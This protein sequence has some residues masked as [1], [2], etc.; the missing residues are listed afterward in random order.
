MTLSQKEYTLE[1]CMHH[2]HTPA[3]YFAIDEPVDPTKQVGRAE[4]MSLPLSPVVTEIIK[5]RA[6]STPGASMLDILT[7][8]LAKT[9]CSTPEVYMEHDQMLKD[10]HTAT[11]QLIQDAGLRRKHG[12]FNIHPSP[13]AIQGY[14]DKMKREQRGGMSV[15][16]A[17]VDMAAADTT[18]TYF[19]LN[20]LNQAEDFSVLLIITPQMRKY[21]ATSEYK[22]SMNSLVYEDDTGGTDKFKSKLFTWLYRSPHTSHGIPVAFMYFHAGK[23]PVPGALAQALVW[24]Y[25]KMETEL[26]GAFHLTA[27]MMDKCPHGHSAFAWHVGTKMKRLLDKVGKDPNVSRSLQISAQA[28]QRQLGDFGAVE[29]ASK[30]KWLPVHETIQALREHTHELS[31]FRHIPEVQMLERMLHSKLFLCHFHALKAVNE[32]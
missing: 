6:A 25:Q 1:V 26:G 8:L 23:N 32:S 15:F 18:N 4:Y 5:K 29:D 16:Q 3:K 11:S 19:H 2:N 14:L 31:A 20:K 28:A 10:K 30:A 27:K 24:S 13:A 7:Y 17:C 21:A 12:L 22:E 9:Q